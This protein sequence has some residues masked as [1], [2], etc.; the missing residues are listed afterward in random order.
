MTP[1]VHRVKRDD[2]IY[3]LFLEHEAIIYST[4]KEDDYMF[5]MFLTIVNWVYKLFCFLLISNLTQGL[6]LWSWVIHGASGD[7]TTRNALLFP[8]VD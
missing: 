6:L 5:I 4:L 8:V 1:Q 2:P 3:K 7:V